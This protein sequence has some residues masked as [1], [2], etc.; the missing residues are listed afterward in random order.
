[1]IVRLLRKKAIG[2]IDEVNCL[3]G[4]APLKNLHRNII[5]V[6]NEDSTFHLYVYWFEV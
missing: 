4:W 2:Q 6:I 5:K 3:G 1:M